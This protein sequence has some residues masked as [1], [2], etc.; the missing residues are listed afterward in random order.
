MASAKFFEELARRPRSSI[1]DVVFALPER[2]VNVGPR[3]DVEQT[4]IGFGVLHHR[5][6]LTI[7]GQNDRA[8][9]FFQLLEKFPDWRRKLVSD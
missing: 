5:L 3:G 1:S 4:L 6:S 9:T 7:D 2:L 8:L